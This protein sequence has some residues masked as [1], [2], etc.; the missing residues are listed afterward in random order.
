ML[1]PQYR[2]LSRAVDDAGNIG[3]ALSF[4]W[5]LDTVPPLPPT[6]L[7][8][9]DPFSLTATQT[10]R[11]QLTGDSSPGQ[12]SFVYNVFP[13]VDSSTVGAT[14]AVPSLPLPNSAPVRLTVT[15][16]TSGV[17]FT[18]RVWSVDQGGLRSAEPTTFSWTYVSKGA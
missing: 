4:D 6:I 9:P 15:A 5:W 14:S 11:L 8:P 3:T 10:F 13:P 2:L 18:I 16:P 1:S 7:D 17:S 12:L